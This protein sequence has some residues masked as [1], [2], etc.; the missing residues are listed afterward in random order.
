MAHGFSRD[1]WYNYIAERSHPPVASAIV[2]KPEYDPDHVYA[3]KPANNY[4]GWKLIVRG[5][6][7]VDDAEVIQS[8]I[9]S[10]DSG[11]IF[12]KEGLY[13]ISD[14]IKGK[15][16]IL[17][18]GEGRNSTILKWT[19]VE[20]G[21]MFDFRECSRFGFRQIR[22]NGNNLADTLIK[23]GS[24]GRT[25]Y[26]TLERIDFYNTLGP[27]LDLGL[28]DGLYTDDTT[29]IDPEFRNCYIGIAHPYSMVRIF[30]GGFGG[31]NAHTH[32]LIK[33][34]PNLAFGIKCYGT[35]FSDS[36][37]DIEI[38]GDDP[39]GVFLFDGCWFE[40][41]ERSIFAK[42]VSTTP[43]H[44]KSITFVE[45]EFGV[46][47][48]HDESYAIIDL[49]NCQTC[50]KF[51]GGLISLASGK[52]FTIKLNDNWNSFYALGTHNADKIQVTGTGSFARGFV[53]TNTLNARFTNSGTATFSGDGSTTQFKI[54]HG[55]VSTPDKGKT[56]VWALSP[57]A[58]DNFWIDVDDT[59]IYVNYKTAP[60]SGTDNVVLGWY[61]EV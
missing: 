31:S 1:R 5:E 35:V 22:L 55:L 2:E 6:A 7:G 15:S 3:W 58:A 53:R 49:T 10:I 45:C 34:D 17:I 60:P 23:T 48:I 57:D 46:D 14:T 8:A 37:Y 39:L 52:T 44:I 13:N 59:Y 25:R 36:V 9:D 21:L 19:G 30:G 18:E 40:Q 32:I 28:K 56:R 26:L 33:T 61:A 38:H 47:T 51:I 43:K 54:A 20:H 12:I 24:S 41:T 4:K 11:I 27:A 50:L 16:F 29:I 42:T